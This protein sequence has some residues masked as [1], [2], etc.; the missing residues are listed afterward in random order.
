MV[1]R[2]RIGDLRQEPER[3]RRRLSA[4]TRRGLLLSSGPEGSPEQ[5]AGLPERWVAAAAAVSQG[6]LTMLHRVRVGRERHGSKLRE[7][8]QQPLEERG[9]VALRYGRAVVVT[10]APRLRRH[11]RHASAVAGAWMAKGSSMG[12][13][14][15]APGRRRGGPLFGTQAAAAPLRGPAQAV[16]R[17]VGQGAVGGPMGCCEP[18]HFAMPWVTCFSTMLRAEAAHARASDAHLGRRRRAG[19]AAPAGTALVPRRA[20][21]VPI[22]ALAIGRRLRPARRTGPCW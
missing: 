3:Q 7:V 2:N 12:D 18:G 11:R 19:A 15:R 9:E 10:P 5:A 20:H 16:R 21:L 13:F 1:K 17:R 14:E 4:P 8:A 6:T 22:L